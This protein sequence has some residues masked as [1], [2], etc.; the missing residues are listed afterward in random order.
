MDADYCPLTNHTEHFEIYEISALCLLLPP[1]FSV[2]VTGRIRK[3][4][5]FVM[6]LCGSQSEPTRWSAHKATEKEA[7]LKH[8]RSHGLAPAGR[9]NPRGLLLNIRNEKET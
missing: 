3:E 5:G 7:M 2:L 1:K 9:S 4:Y 6:Y 8:L